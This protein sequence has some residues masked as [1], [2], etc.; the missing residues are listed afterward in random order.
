M[1]LYISHGLTSFLQAC[2]GG[3]FD[4]G[5]ES[6]TTDGPSDAKPTADQDGADVK[7]LRQLVTYACILATYIHCTWCLFETVNSN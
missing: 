3:K 6:E 2:R 1:W 5:V 4:Y 7:V